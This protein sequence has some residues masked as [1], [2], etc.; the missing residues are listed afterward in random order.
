MSS[1][2]KMSE[3]S[4][5]DINGGSGGGVRNKR[6]DNV[7][8]LTSRCGS[9]TVALGDGNTSGGA[10]TIDGGKLFEDGEVTSNGEDLSGND[11]MSK[12]S[13]NDNNRGS[14]GG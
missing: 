8:T 4:N 11:K 9:L 6:G 10:V 2:D 14:G 7:R 3:D 1:N 12:D 5:D 13:N